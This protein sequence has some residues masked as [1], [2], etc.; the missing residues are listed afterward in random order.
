MLTVSDVRCEYAVN[1]L[2]LRTPRPGSGS[3]AF[4]R[5]PAE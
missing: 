5:V 2:G 1:P 4:E 3:Y